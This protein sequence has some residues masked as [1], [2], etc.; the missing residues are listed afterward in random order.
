MDGVKLAR[1]KNKDKKKRLNNSSDP[2]KWVQILVKDSTRLAIKDYSNLSGLK[3]WA[4]VDLA[5][6][7]F[8]GKHNKYAP[9][10]KIIRNSEPTQQSKPKPTQQNKLEPTHQSKPEPTQQSKPKPTHQSKPKLTQQKTKRTSSDKSNS[11]LF[12][13]YLTSIIESSSDDDNIKQTLD[14]IKKGIKLS[15]NTTESNK[16]PNA[17]RRSNKR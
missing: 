11:N 9:T 4:F 6:S 2:E 14:F 12:D 1:I 17:R 15:G 5:V 10:S 16:F 13:N 8:I 3:M 7:D